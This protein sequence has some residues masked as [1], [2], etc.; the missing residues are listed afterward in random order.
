MIRESIDSRYP[1]DPVNAQLHIL[2]DDHIG[3]S[4]K[5]VPNKP[6]TIVGA[7][8]FSGVRFNFNVHGLV[9]LGWSGQESPS[10]GEYFWVQT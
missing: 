6:V 4:S 3:F 2:G 8:P 1:M 10:C 9:L 7:R 5:V